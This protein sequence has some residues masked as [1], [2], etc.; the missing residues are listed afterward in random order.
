MEPTSCVRSVVLAASQFYHEA[1]DENLTNLMRQIDVRLFIVF[2]M[3]TI[4]VCLRECTVALSAN[5]RRERGEGEWRLSLNMQGLELNEC[6]DVESS[7]TWMS[8]PPGQ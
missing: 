2:H 4:I 3:S 7:Q 1:H 5:G 6:L 8:S